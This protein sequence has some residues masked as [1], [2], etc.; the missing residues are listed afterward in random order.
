GFNDAG[1]ASGLAQLGYGDGDEATVVGYGGN[2]SAKY[3]TTYFRRTFSVTNPANFG[4]LALRILRD[5][6]AVVYLN[7]VEAFRTNM[8]T[9]TINHTT[10]AS[11]A[12]TGADE[13][14]FVS[15]PLSPSLLVAGANVIAVEL[16]QA[17]PTSSDISF[18]LEL[19]AGPSVAVTRGPYLQLGTP[20]SIVVRWRTSAPVVGRVQFGPSPGAALGSAQ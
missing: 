19:L 9:G 13:S 20:T 8:P 6:G 16:H 18:D 17:D 12:V 15:A 11:A 4:S 5:D 14:T 10:L 1:W 3:I 7:G 2:A